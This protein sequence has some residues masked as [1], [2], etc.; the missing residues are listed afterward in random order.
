MD[1]CHYPR[2][3]SPGPFFPCPAPG[4][5]LTWAAPGRCSLTEM[6]ED[7]DTGG[8]GQN[9]EGSSSAGSTR[10]C[11]HHLWPSSQFYLLEGRG[12]R[13]TTLTL[14]MGRESESHS[15]FCPVYCQMAESGSHSWFCPGVWITQL[16]LS[17]VLPDGHSNQHVCN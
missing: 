5:A 17:C 4:Q 14:W 6:P 12:A 2:K 11:Q 7:G 16:V 3:A 8:P 9:W 1:H 10:H 15:W 13:T